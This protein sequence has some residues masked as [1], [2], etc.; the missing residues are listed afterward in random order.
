M[1]SFKLLAMAPFSQLRA[2]SLCAWSGDRTEA[3]Y[4]LAKF[5]HEVTRGVAQLSLGLFHHVWAS[6]MGRNS[7]NNGKRMA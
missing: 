2:R 6:T 7:Q 1:P 4:Q 5:V 3:R